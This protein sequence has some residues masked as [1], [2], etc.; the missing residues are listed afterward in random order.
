MHRMT[1]VHHMYLAARRTLG[2]LREGISLV[3]S[4]V[5]VEMSTLSLTSIPTAH[6]SESKYSTR[7]QSMTLKRHRQM[8]QNSI[9]G[10]SHGLAEV[11][12]TRETGS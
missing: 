1:A 4:F 2:V 6:M 7:V 5:V 9:F 12:V 8:E 11:G 3:E 10:A